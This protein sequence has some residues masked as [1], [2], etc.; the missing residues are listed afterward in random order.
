[1][2]DVFILEVIA[3]MKPALA[4]ALLCGALIFLPLPYL[5]DGMG[6][7]GNQ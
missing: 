6:I 7:Y 2:P 5:M 4:F 3:C 1:V